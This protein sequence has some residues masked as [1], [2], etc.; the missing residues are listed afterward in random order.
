VASSFAKVMTVSENCVLFNQPSCNWRASGA[1]LLNDN[2]KLDLAAGSFLKRIHHLRG[3]QGRGGISKKS[4][5]KDDVVI[6]E[7]QVA[8]LS[9]HFRRFLPGPRHAKTAA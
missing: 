5:E 3:G 7:L 8:A 9:C 6:S 2:P 1:R 4:Q